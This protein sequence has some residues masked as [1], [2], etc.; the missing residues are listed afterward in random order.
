MTE[1]ERLRLRFRELAKEFFLNHDA[2]QLIAIHR[3][4]AQKLNDHVH[5]SGKR[6]GHVAIY[7]PMRYELPVR[8]IVAQVAELKGAELLIPRWNEEKMW[9]DKT[10]DLI[11]VPGLFA[12]K[13][14]NRLGRGK[15]Y[16]DRY[17]ATSG[18]HTIFLGYSFQVIDVLPV[19][20]HDRRMDAV[21]F[22]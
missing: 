20:T 2:S 11:I 16:Y 12:D 10:P 3:S 4:I 21:I 7:E 1:K 15:G 13:A 14:G 19:E 6:L 18:A 8:D 22:A 9:F 17:L 5:A